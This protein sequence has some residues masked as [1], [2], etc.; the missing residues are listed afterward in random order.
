MHCGQWSERNGRNRLHPSTY[1]QG[2][3]FQQRQRGTAHS[4]VA[5][6]LAM[7]MFGAVVDT[8]LL[9]TRSTADAMMVVLARD[10]ANRLVQLR[11]QVEGT[12]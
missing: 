11:F 8:E 10:R 2:L 5:A 6:H 12:Y 3:T 7:L 4:R 1:G 9:L